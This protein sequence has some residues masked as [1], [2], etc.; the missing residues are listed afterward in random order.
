MVLIATNVVAAGRFGPT[1]LFYESSYAGGVIPAILFANAVFNV[2]AWSTFLRRVMKDP[3]ARDTSGRPTPFL[4]VHIV[5]VTIALLLA[6]LSAVAA[7]LMIT[8]VW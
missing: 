6:A 1:F 5:Q 4:T 8:G 7:V 2:F 3:R